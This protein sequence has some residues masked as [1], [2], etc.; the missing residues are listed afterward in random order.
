MVADRQRERSLSV[1]E[2]L[3]A[4][5]EGAGQHPAERAITLLAA[6]SPDGSRHT[7]EHLSVGD[8]DGRLLAL[9]ESTFGARIVG[10]V[11]CPGC[12][13]PMEISFRASDVRVP[14]AEPVESLWIDVGD[15]AV[16]FRLPNSLD[17][18]TVATTED[19]AGVRRALLQRCVLA[20]GG[21][22]DAQT[23]DDLGNEVVDAIAARMGEA[24]PQANVELAV[25]CPACGHA[26]HAAFDVASF[27]WM[28]VEA[29]ARRTLHDV[30][31]LARAYGWPEHAILAMS[32]TRRQ[33]YLDMASG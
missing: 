12:G 29:W 5:D 3:D 30:H 24:D 25:E 1:A 17:L 4:W 10:L 11:S 2:L 31:T 20:V 14:A 6:A 26:W 28:Q 19:V 23:A 13:E 16:H 22:G 32:A 8:R 7:L 21:R 33:A 9:C 15:T 27:F 18:A